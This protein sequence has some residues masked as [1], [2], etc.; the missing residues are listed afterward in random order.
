M[1][2]LPPPVSAFP[3]PNAETYKPGDL[4]VLRY[5]R[6]PPV[7]VVAIYPWQGS[8]AGFMVEHDG[9]GPPVIDGFD[10]RPFRG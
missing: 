10:V 7:R 6:R 3:A 9:S 4:I 2:N 8:R 1:P 5:R